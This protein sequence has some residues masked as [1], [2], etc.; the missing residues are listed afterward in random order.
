[1]KRRA[2]APLIRTR[3]ELWKRVE[4][5]RP[6]RQ[7]RGDR[8][9]LAVLDREAWGPAGA[10]GGASL[11]FVSR[12]LRER[13]TSRFP[14]SQFAARDPRSLVD[15]A[16]V[17]AEANRILS[18][19]WDALGAPVRVTGNTLDWRTHPVSRVAT[20]ALH[21]SRVRYASDVL[22]GDVKYLWEVNRHAELVRLAQGY[23][24]TR[25]AEFAHAAL[26]LLDSWIA[27]NPPGIG[28]NWISTVDVAFRTI[29]WCWTWALT[30][31]SD[32]WTDERVGR[33]VWMIEQC[34]RFIG[35]YDSVHHSPNTHLT[36]EAL[37]LLYIGS[38]FPE[39]RHAERW[40]A[41]GVAIL[42]EEVPHQFL[43]DGMHYERCT[44]YHRYHLEF[45][46]HALAIA[47]SRRETWAEAFRAPLSRGVEASMQLRRPDG[48]WPVLGDED[49]GTTVR[50]GT[51][52]VTDQNELLVAAAALLGQPEPCRRAA[53]DATSLAW[54]LVGDEAWRRVSAP[55]T[56][57]GLPPAFSLGTAGYFGARDDWSDAAWYCVV[58]A[59]PHGG[60]ATG[61]AHTDLGHVEIAHGARWITVDPGCSVYTSEPARRNWF[62]GQRAHG[63]LMVDDI[64]L[65]VPSTAFGWGRVA[66]TPAV[67]SADHAAYWWCRLTYAYPLAHGSVEHERQVVL[68]RSAGVVVC[69]FVRGHGNHT[70]VTRWPLGVRQDPRQLVDG[71]CSLTMD[72]VRASWF[73]ASGNRCLTAVE[74]T[75]R[76]PRFGIEVDA[77]ALVLT[78]EAAALPWYGVVA[79]TCEQD[80]PRFEPNDEGLKVTVTR[81]A[82][83][84]PAAVWLKPGVS[85]T[86]IEAGS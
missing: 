6:A 57:H 63:T 59:G 73:V 77:S 7:W 26:A 83:R 8:D 28:I 38:V 75:R 42:R 72:G 50:L 54:W 49:S 17:I 66:P 84:E 52:D 69:D 22:G 85:P 81:C 41:L 9:T 34:A 40:R 37:G 1:M 5:L 20:P 19:E 24:L 25:R 4:R 45:Y 70:I 62:R 12:T 56:G 47:R 36:G 15:A 11:A 21:F 23:W 82:T 65:A 33:F 55:T 67:E 74:P 13:A 3:Q 44:G 31:E 32:A 80:P 16:V 43:A 46:L 18:G 76:S 60:D 10:E 53:G 30:A 64:E 35:R 78:C 51:R 29:A 61:H 79:F 27:Q 68:V 48:T 86:L 2:I 71:A 39:L 14:A 58:D